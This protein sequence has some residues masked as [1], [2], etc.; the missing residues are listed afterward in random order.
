MFG[1][2]MP[3]LILIGVVALL[4]V[5]PKK[6]PDLAKTL[7]KGLNEFRK[8]ATDV[9]DGLKDTIKADDIKKDV[10]SVKNSLLYGRDDEEESSPAGSA[11]P[12]E[13]AKSDASAA[14]KGTAKEG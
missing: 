11:S 3:E 1:I 9:T 4:V 8:T 12:L 2:G 10:E 7:G 14:G 13:T 5:G 6:L